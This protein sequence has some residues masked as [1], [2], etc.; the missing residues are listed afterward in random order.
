M[1]REKSKA[2]KFKNSF[3]QNKKFRFVPPHPPQMIMLNKH[4]LPG[5]PRGNG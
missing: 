1:G 5:L 2:K 4:N 3:L